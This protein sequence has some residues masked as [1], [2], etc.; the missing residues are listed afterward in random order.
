[1]L[2][3]Q[4]LMTLAT[5]ASLNCQLHLNIVRTVVKTGLKIWTVILPISI[6]SDDLMDA[7]HLL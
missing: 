5:T 6:M 2:Q 3:H 1:M 7:S 4:M